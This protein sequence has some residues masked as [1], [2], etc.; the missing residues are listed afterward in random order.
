VQAESLVEAKQVLQGA[1]H[2]I[3]VCVKPEAILSMG[4]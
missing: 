4:Y 2:L 1:L 3:T